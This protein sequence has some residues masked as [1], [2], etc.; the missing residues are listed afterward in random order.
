[1]GNL[2]RISLGSFEQSVQTADFV[3]GSSRSSAQVR[4]SR[5]EDKVL[6][7]WVGSRLEGVKSASAK[8]VMRVTLT[9]IVLKNVLKVCSQMFL[10][11]C[12]SLSGPGL[13]SRRRN[14]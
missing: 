1:M 11:R 9:G 3:E 2:L 6:K 10:H 7:F 14:Q 12:H 5:S 4:G 8:A 13:D